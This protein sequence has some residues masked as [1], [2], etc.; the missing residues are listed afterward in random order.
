[1]KRTF[2]IAN[3]ATWTALVSAALI[4]VVAVLGVESFRLSQHGMGLLAAKNMPHGNVWRLVGHWWIGLLALV[5]AIATLQAGEREGLRAL[6]MAGYFW[7]IAAVAYAL[8]GLWPLDLKDLESRNNQLHSV[9]NTVWWLAA[10]AGA[11]AWALARRGTMPVVFA[12]VL[13]I[14]GVVKTLEWLPDGQR[15]LAGWLQVFGWLGTLVQE[16]QRVLE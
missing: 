13:V 16:R 12:A 2:S 15:A 4:C 6:R 1:M 9:A 14:L 5:P 10:T 3:A 8:Q 7:I 11:V